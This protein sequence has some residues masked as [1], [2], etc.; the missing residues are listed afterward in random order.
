MCFLKPWPYFW[1][2]LLYCLVLDPQQMRCLAVRLSLKSCCPKF[3][4]GL[5]VSFM[6]ISSHF[7]ANY[8][9]LSQIEVQ[10]VILRWWT[11]LKRN[12]FKSYD[13]DA[14]KKQKCKKHY[15]KWGV[16]YNIEKNGNWKYVLTFCVIPKWLSELQFCV[17]CLCSWQNKG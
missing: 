15:T 8:K 4:T 17:G 6:T 7:F 14:K 13:T 16:F 2:L 1:A 10:M 5:I 11:G 3:A 12:W 9:N